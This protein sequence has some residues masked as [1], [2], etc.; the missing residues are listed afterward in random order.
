MKKELIQNYTLRISQANKSGII[1]ILYELADT[2]ISDALAAYEKEDLVSFKS[3]CGRAGRC[4]ADLLEALDFSYELAYPLMRL[5]IFISK[6]ISL[7]GIKKDP[8]GLHHAK[9][10]LGEL[11]EAFAEVAGQDLS[12]PVMQNS[13]TVYAGLTY[14]KSQLNEN[15]SD[16]GFL[17]GFRV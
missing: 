16:E 6:E 5:Y 8:A 9:R 2:Y 10:L 14:G 3:N 4:V 15:L 11:R 7:S 12:E 13:Q 17:R 1:V